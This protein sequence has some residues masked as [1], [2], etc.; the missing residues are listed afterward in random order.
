MRLLY[1]TK[2]STR[3]YIETASGA[4]N[5]RCQSPKSTLIGSAS[6][7]TKKKTLKSSLQIQETHHIIEIWASARQNLQ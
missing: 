3:T 1:I 4:L 7:Q 5:R 6:S 2:F